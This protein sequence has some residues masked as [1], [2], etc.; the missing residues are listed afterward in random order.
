M[1]D[2]ELMPIKQAVQDMQQAV[3]EYS[4]LFWI[5]GIAHFMFNTKKIIP[6]RSLLFF[7]S[8]LWDMIY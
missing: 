2:T 6:C 4:F 8:Y 5:V 3:A 7:C 1:Q